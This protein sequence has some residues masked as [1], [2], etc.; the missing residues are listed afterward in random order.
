PDADAKRQPY[1][2]RGRIAAAPDHLYPVGTSGHHR[3]ITPRPI[4]ANPALPGQNVLWR[5]PRGTNIDAAVFLF[6][7]G[8]QQ[9]SSRKPGSLSPTY[10][11]H[12]RGVLAYRFK[13]TDHA[14]CFSRL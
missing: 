10:R 9:T 5:A 13:P 11:Y 14:L 2:R 6:Y 7:L 12:Y 4:A 3:A 1:H 8:R